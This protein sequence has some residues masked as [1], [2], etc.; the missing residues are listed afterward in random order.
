MIENEAIRVTTDTASFNLMVHNVW[1]GEKSTLKKLDVVEDDRN[2]FFKGYFLLSFMTFFYSLKNF[3]EFFILTKTTNVTRRW[4]GTGTNG[5][6]QTYTEQRY[7]SKHSGSYY[8]L[9]HRDAYNELFKQEYKATIDLMK[10]DDAEELK[11]YIQDSDVFTFSDSTN[12]T[13]KK[14]KEVISLQQI[15]KKGCNNLSQKLVSGAL[16]SLSG[17]SDL[18]AKTPKDD[19]TRQIKNWA[20]IIYPS[21]TNKCSR[22][23]GKKHRHTTTQSTRVNENHQTTTSTVPTTITEL[24]VVISIDFEWQL[25]Q[26]EEKTA[27]GE[28]LKHSQKRRDFG[29]V[30][31]VQYAIYLPDYPAIDIH[32]IIFN[33]GDK[34]FNFKAL[35]LK[36]TDIIQ[37]E[38]YAL[39]HNHQ[40]IVL[41]LKHLKLLL[42]G[43]KL[44]ICIMAKYHNWTL[45]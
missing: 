42:N 15:Q 3:K 33:D 6:L 35:M 44:P 39:D 4:I 31:S 25:G 11:Q 36:F 5:Q 38:F 43:T 20:K 17:N 37:R 32:G 29:D 2:T 9:V 41:K 13:P 14:G 8:D 18:G 16:L 28:V 23:D 40:P 30:L 12:G 26:H 45:D 1:A 34:G 27:T 7:L 22:R 10:K 21:L 19:I 24:S